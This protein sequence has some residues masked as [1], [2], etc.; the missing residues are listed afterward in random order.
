[1]SRLPDNV[2]MYPPLLKMLATTVSVPLAPV[3][4]GRLIASETRAST[5][6]QR[7]HILTQIWRL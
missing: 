4:K 6:E 3:D 1:M 5:N 2:S 7:L